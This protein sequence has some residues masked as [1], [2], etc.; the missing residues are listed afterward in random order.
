M[1]GAARGVACD[2]PVQPGGKPVIGKSLLAALGP[3]APVRLRAPA[4]AA[5]AE[6]GGAERRATWSWCI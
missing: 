1:T 4:R 6:A 2:V 5:G 3:P